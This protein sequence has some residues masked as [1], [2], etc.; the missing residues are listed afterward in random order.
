MKERHG[1]KSKS[2]RLRLGLGSELTTSSNT[3]KTLNPIKLEPRH[4]RSKEAQTW[5]NM[6]ETISSNYCLNQNGGAAGQ[7]S[8]AQGRGPTSRN[9]R[10]SIHRG[11]EGRKNRHMRDLSLDR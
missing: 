9:S 5:L 4:F 11:S 2:V 10:Q 1:G 7:G 6:F 8:D 3:V